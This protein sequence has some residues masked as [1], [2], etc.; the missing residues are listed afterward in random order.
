MMGDQQIAGWARASFAS[1][2]RALVDRC[3]TPGSGGAFGEALIDRR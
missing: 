2:R 3:A 1:A